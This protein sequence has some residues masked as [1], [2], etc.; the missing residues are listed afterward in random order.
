MVSL[1]SALEQIMQRR[2]HISCSHNVIVLDI[3]DC[4]LVV[5]S[6]KSCLCMAFE[7]SAKCSP[8][9]MPDDLPLPAAVRLV[10]MES[11]ISHQCET[12]CGGTTIR[13]VRSGSSGSVGLPSIMFAALR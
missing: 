8:V 12:K 3:G 7:E 2:L 10:P 11:E 5:Q 9:A 1:K 13:V 6:G 4:L